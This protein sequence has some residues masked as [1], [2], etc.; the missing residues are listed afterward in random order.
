M[1][2]LALVAAVLLAGCGSGTNESWAPPQSLRLGWREPPCARV[3]IE[4]ARLTVERTRWRVDAKVFNDG[5]AL[6]I[7]KPHAATGTYFG[8][9]RGDRLTEVALRTAVLA[10][11]FTP[12][13]PRRL[14]GGA[15]WSGTYS[16]PGR[17]P[18][19]VPLRLVFGR[20][21]RGDDAT[22]FVCISTH[23]VEL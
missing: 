17:L 3:R 8:I 9:A 1:K 13:L 11:R 22:A 23:Q 15:S 14:E 4:I 5:R 7:G 21:S 6:S 18:S 16:G 2:Q 20:F 19:G 12:R 10:D